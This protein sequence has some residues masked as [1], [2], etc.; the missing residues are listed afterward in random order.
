MNDRLTTDI[1]QR[2]AKEQGAVLKDS[3][4]RLRVALIWPNTYAC[5]MASLGFQQLYRLLNELPFVVCERA[6]LPDNPRQYDELDTELFTY[7]TLT[8]VRDFHV[9]AFSVAYELD[10]FHLLRCLSLARVP[11]RARD[12]QEDDPLVIAGGIALTF[13][14][15]PIAE[16]LDAICIGEAEPLLERWFELLYQS[17][18]VAPGSREEIL[19]AQAEL[20]GVFVPSLYKLDW[21]AQGNLM[22]VET[23][24]PAPLSVVKSTTD[25]DYNEPARGS[26]FAASSQFANDLLV[27]IGRGCGRGCKFC[28]S[29]HVTNPVRF[30][31]GEAVVQAA[32]AAEAPDFGRVALVASA[33]GDYP[34][35][36][37]LLTSL[38]AEGFR[39][40]VS[41]LRVEQ[42]KLATLKALAQSGGRTVTIAPEAATERLRFA[43]GKKTR[44]E[45]FFHFAE[46]AQEARIEQLKL[47]FLLGLPAETDDDI[48][49]LGGFLTEL[50]S[51]CPG[52]AVKASVGIFVPK[53]AT[54]FQWAPMV[55]E[56]E[57]TR[58]L[59]LARQALSKLRKVSF[60]LDAP[61]EALIQALLARG[62]APLFP[63]LEA[64]AV[65]GPKLKP[66]LKGL[67]AQEL[68]PDLLWSER[69]AEARFPW[70]LFDFGMAREKLWK[71]WT[72]TFEGAPDEAD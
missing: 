18:E 6:F 4:G 36:A 25:F 64:L 53:P 14:P 30:H 43:L 67:R 38:T 35:L 9:L 33:A 31:P 55:V 19:R 44:D 68:D 21:D 22:S 42:T 48:L 12:R 26:L 17:R 57:L 47:Y 65:K 70:E 54:P 59:V 51:R 23:E 58:R 56:P 8:P 50:K 71:R 61:G 66:L 69:P 62:G 41:S 15:F 46:L 63:V 11:V 28:V 24:P 32:K 27:E 29:G 49:A 1:R 16:A 13:N 39:A 52:V 72:E 3:G 7:E 10:Y 5:G 40:S 37:E 2:V 45:E 34:G 60:D 20:P